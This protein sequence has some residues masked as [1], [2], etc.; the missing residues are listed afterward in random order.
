MISAVVLTNNSESVIKRCLNSLSFCSET[1]I[2]DDF[3]ND[4]TAEIAKK[5]GARVYQRHLDGN[6]A[7]QRNFGLRR[8]K[9]K[10]VLFIDD[11]EVVTRELADEIVQ[12]TSKFE[13]G[14]S[15]F[16]LTRQDL[17]WERVLRYGEPGR[18]KLLRLAKKVAGKWQREVHEY[19]NIKGDTKTLKHPIIHYPHQTLSEFILS[20]NHMSSLH[21]KANQK[22]EKGSGLFKIIIWPLGKF[23][24]NYLIKL[25]FLDG[26]QGIVHALTMSFHSYL[27]WSK[28][29]L[30]QRKK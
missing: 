13:L 2:I 10:W 8:A 18:I 6:F 21:A 19:W 7:K 29:W 25:G 17:L 30:L 22:E 23:I 16:Y 4:K 11:D 20:V 26:T 15:G 28:L 1:I 3:S 5:L 9:E 27:S 14:Y 12:I 24:N